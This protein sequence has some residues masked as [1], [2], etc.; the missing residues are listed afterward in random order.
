V[1][2][3]L[4]R[5]VPAGARHR[6]AGHPHAAGLIPFPMEVSP[7]SC[8]GQSR[9]AAQAAGPVPVLRVPPPADPPVPSVESAGAAAPSAVRLR[10]THSARVRVNGPV[11]G[12]GYEFSPASP[13]GSVDSRDA[14]G[15]VG[16]GLFRRVY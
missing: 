16:T 4:R 11:S 7:M 15:L 10:Y 1:A 14:E 9:A 6:A 5:R 3:D 12:R 13:V 8:C 2:G